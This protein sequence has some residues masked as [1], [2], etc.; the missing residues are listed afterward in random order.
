MSDNV[1][2]VDLGSRAYS[3]HVGQRLLDSLGTLLG[4]VA[5]SQK[6]LLVFDEAVESPWGKMMHKLLVKAGYEVATHVMAAGEAAKTVETATAIWSKLADGAFDRDSTIVALGGGVV[7]DV[8]GFAAAAYLRGIAFIQ[9]PTTLLAMVDSSVGGKTGVNLPQGKNLVGAFWQPRMVLADIDFLGTL[10]E[11]QR[12]S[13][14]AEIIK[15]G[16]I[17]DAELFAFLEENIATLFEGLHSA[18][19]I[20]VIRRSVE[21]KADVVVADE[22]E[23]GLRRILNFGHTIGHAIEAEQH[24][25][26][27]THG[28]AIAVGMVVASAL[29]RIHHPDTWTEECHARL[30]ALLEKAGL[31]TRFPAGMSAEALI[32][33]TS[34]DKKVRK[35]TLRWVLPVRI[36]EVVISRD[37]T[38]E[39]AR[40]VLVGLG[41]TAGA[42][43]AGV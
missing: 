30:V 17:R 10:S 33:R 11:R 22:R 29:G 3:I 43:H 19:L 18:D 25:E 41:A 12:V 2:V 40:E 8:A 34:V 42:S 38:I 27:M 23:G 4:D 31:P 21:I 6:V 36:G 5:Q 15:Y 32:E 24:Y 39:Q 16:V 28:E 26:G 37:V 14:L 1:V 35:G 7:G 20:H 13:G 9:I